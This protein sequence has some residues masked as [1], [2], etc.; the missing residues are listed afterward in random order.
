MV[1]IDR[2]AS[3]CPHCT[4]ELAIVSD[5]DLSDRDEFWRVVRV[6]GLPIRAILGGAFLGALGMSMMFSA[7]DF[8]MGFGAVVGAIAGYACSFGLMVSSMNEQ[9]VVRS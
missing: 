6:T 5:V 8:T 3:R 4:S 9:K 1:P 7:N 2:F